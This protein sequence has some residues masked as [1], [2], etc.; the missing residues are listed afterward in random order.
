MQRI[1]E[2]ELMDEA[3]QARAYAMAD[4]SESNQRFVECF[5]ATFPGLLEH[6]NVLDLGCGPGDIV[7]RLAARHANLVVHGLDGSDA[8]LHFASERLHEDPRLGGRVQFVHG[9]LPGATLPL[10]R[11]DAVISNSLLH[12]LHDPEVFWQAV[13]EA[14][15]PGAAVL[16]MDL[17][18][19][20]STRRAQALVDAYAATEPE[21][22]RHDF[23]AS[24]CAAF[25]PAEVEAQLRACGLDGLVVS[26]VSDRHLLVTGHLPAQ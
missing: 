25:E 6:A 7:L 14:G 24:L 12:H 1:P 13:R 23:F 19:P 10:A 26:T 4:F 21:V 3:G 17:F 20:E 2:P 18:R 11:Y 8:M 22:L 5:E 16:V 9:V 15:A